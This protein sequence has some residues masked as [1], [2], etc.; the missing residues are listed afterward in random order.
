LKK[1]DPGRHF[2]F[3]FVDLY[4]KGFRRLFVHGLQNIGKGLACQWPPPSVN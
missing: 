3:F 1:G 2:H 4:S